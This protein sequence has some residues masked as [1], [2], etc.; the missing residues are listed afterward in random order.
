MT[1]I[2]PV[3]HPQGEREIRKTAWTRGNG[4]RSLAEI[5]ADEAAT[6][7]QGD[8]AETCV[9]ESIDLLVARR[10][11]RFDLV[12]TLVPHNIQLDSVASLTI[13]VG[14]GP[15]SPLAVQV[16][17]RIGEALG[18]PV[19]LATVFRT[20]DEAGHA[21]DRMGCLAAPYPGLALR[22]V[23]D[24]RATALLDH[25]TSSA[26]LVVGAPGGSWIQ[27]QL[28][29]PGHRLQ[30]AAPGGTLI[31]RSS[32]RRCFQEAVNPAGVAVGPQL[33]VEAAHALVSYPTVPVAAEGRLVGILRSERLAEA[34][35]HQFIED[36]ME[37]PVSVSAT[38]PAEVVSDLGEYL[39]FGPV[40][41][42]GSNGRL[43]GVIH[44]STEGDSR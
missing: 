23:G 30:V 17:A 13:A 43:I 27:R 4:C 16:G 9:S 40:P 38:E 36:I 44:S 5:L 20:A 2:D 11:T 28:F 21:I 8:L 24:D 6:P 33:P 7:V 41:V 37:A 42:V 34:E 26:L 22:A 39:A 12:S 15:H 18:V 31:V 25:L 3:A 32:P 19:E 14:D 35:P 29:G 1:A 10:M